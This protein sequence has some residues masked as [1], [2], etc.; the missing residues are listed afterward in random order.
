[1][2]AFLFLEL[3]QKF[4]YNLMRMLKKIFI[5]FMVAPLLSDPKY[6]QNYDTIFSTHIP[7]IW[8]QVPNAIFYNLIAQNSDSSS[9]VS[10]IDSTLLYI[11]K[12]TFYWGDTVSWQLKGYNSNGTHIYSSD[13]NQFQIGQKKFNDI[14]LI[15]SDTINMNGGITFF[16]TWYDWASGAID[17]D[18]NEIWNDG[19]LQTM[20]CHIDKHGQ[21]FGSQD[22]PFD[23]V[24]NRGIQLNSKH[25]IIWEEPFNMRLDPH[26]LKRLP[27][28]N[29]IGLKAISQQGPIP[30]GPWQE[31]YQNLGYLADGETN[32]VNWVAQ[33][34][35][36]F[37]HLSNAIEWE[38]NPFN[39][40]SL[41]D[42]DS[43]LG[44]WW[45]VG[46]GY[47]WLH[48][49][50]LYYEENNSEI[51]FSNRH[52]SRVSK[53]N[54]P[55]GDL[56]WM[57]GLPE[58]YIYNG[59][60]HICNDILFSWQHDV[61]VLDNGNIL[62]FDNGNLSQQ[63]F[64]IDLPR[65]RILEISIDSENSCN[66]VWEYELPQDFFAV[67]MGSTQILNNGNIQITSG[68]ECGTV[69]EI[70]REGEIVWQVQLGLDNCQNSLYK[71]FR[72][73]SLYPYLFSVI[74]KNYTIINVEQNQNG[75]FLEDN[76]LAFK[77]YNEGSEDLDVLYFFSKVSSIEEVII[78]DTVFLQI[79]LNQ[80][81]EQSI[82]FNNLESGLHQVTLNIKR[83]PFYNPLEKININLNTEQNLALANLQEVTIKNSNN[84][85]NP[86]NNRTTII[87]DLP[88]F[89]F[90]ELII[91][92]LKG[93]V[94]N[95]L[96]NSN[97][98]SG[99]KSIEWNATNNHGQSVSGG[100]YI[101]S[102]EAGDFRETKKMILLK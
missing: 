73:N 43:H 81:I 51:Y 59:N 38:W 13:I 79:P 10:I 102:I 61:K 31:H 75:I 1:M 69:L 22:Y 6:P 17:Q 3:W 45:N 93:N 29:V 56:I 2:R 82:Y 32:E 84:F 21:I 19:D 33:K 28:G 74:I 85:P 70:N 16:S 50:S 99:K 78:S 37:N 24:P 18:G 89:S 87:Y 68:N 65:S 57:M 15:N 42:F 92:D 47:D 25:E 30:I 11:D 9:T 100:V 20:I 44:T 46:W 71:G 101:Y 40:Y 66:V 36:I 77:I 76:E 35:V 83:F 14:V 4:D 80:F 64:D 34:I 90:V 52:I 5:L 72:V 49:N 53:I 39:Y 27:N 94:V 41:D 62:L 98:P 7:F 48:S 55:D 58:E 60:D 12:N 96:V 54:Y 86:F 63:L 95:N 23:D 67:G 91:Y 97:Q 8:N 88:K 26:D